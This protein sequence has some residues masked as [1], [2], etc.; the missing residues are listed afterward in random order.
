MIDKEEIIRAL[1]TWFQPGDVFEIRVL[2]ALSAEM[3]RPA[4][5][6]GIF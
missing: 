5:R 1:T 4:H 3:M 6:I 2:N